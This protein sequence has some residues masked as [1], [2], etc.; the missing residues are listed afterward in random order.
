MDFRFIQEEL[1][2]GVVNKD[3]VIEQILNLPCLYIILKGQSE[4]FCLDVYSQYDNKEIK[5][6]LVYSNLEIAMEAIKEFDIPSCW[7]L[8]QWIEIREGLK[9]CLDLKNIEGMAIDSLP[10]GDK[11]NGLIIDK[12]SLVELSNMTYL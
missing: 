6:P 1:N 7:N 10:M 4:A 3:E 8:M 2:N 11:L 9:Y 5:I 12:E